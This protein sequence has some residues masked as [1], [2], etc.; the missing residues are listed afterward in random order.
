MNQQEHRLSV[1][2]DAITTLQES[3]N[4]YRDDVKGH[5]PVRM[6]IELAAATRRGLEDAVAMQPVGRVTKITDSVRKRIA[7]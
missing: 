6:W 7:G 3:L 1:A 4:E 2:L 5:A